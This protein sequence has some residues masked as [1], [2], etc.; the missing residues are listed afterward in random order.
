MVYVMQGK[1]IKTAQMIV[2]HALAMQI[3]MGM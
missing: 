1:I 3:L 2:P